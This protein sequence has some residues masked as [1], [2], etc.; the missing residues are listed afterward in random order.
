MLTDHELQD[1]ARTVADLP[2]EHER[3]IIDA[4]A[5]I[6]DARPWEE[7]ERHCAQ[8]LLRGHGVFPRLD[9]PDF[10][11]PM[12]SVSRAALP[13]NQVSETARRSAG[14][15]SKCLRTRRAMASRPSKV[16]ISI[17]WRWPLWRRRASR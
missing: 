2:P 3:I 17:R 11:P 7:A 1:F 14:A 5:A 4:V 13:H 12:T 6:R 15:S 16:M 9:A 10:R 8:R